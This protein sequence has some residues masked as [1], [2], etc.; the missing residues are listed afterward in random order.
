[1]ELRGENYQDQFDLIRQFFSNY[2][3]VAVAIDSTGQGDF[4]PDMFEYH[5]EWQDEH[6]GLYRIK[7]SQSSKDLM[8]KNLKVTIQQLLT[9]LP[10]L[11]TKQGERFKQQMLDLQ[12]QY[13]GVDNKLS[14][15]HPEQA[16]AHDDYA[17]SWAL[18]EWA[19]AKWYA[20]GE[21]QAI[22]LSAT[23]EKIVPKE[24]KNEQG[25]IEDYWP[26]ID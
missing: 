8:Y 6:S 2:N 26:G 11:S 10:K 23:K 9:T 22:S 18:A 24:N 13:K 16:D 17:D 12:Q 21:P 19:H 20:G 15:H 7:F 1:M 14:V 25:E 3:V 4:M 5:T